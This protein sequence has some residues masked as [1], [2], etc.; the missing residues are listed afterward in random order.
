MNKTKRKQNFDLLLC[1]EEAK[2]P[3]EGGDLLQR[4]LFIIR[5]ILHKNLSEE[6]CLESNSFCFEPTHLVP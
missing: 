1:G 5:L 6:K 4:N 3:T 2:R